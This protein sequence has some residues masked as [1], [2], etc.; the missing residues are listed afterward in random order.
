MVEEFFSNEPI[1]R[2]QTHLPLSKTTPK[3]LAYCRIT[4]GNENPRFLI[5]FSG[6]QSHVEYLKIMYFSITD[7][8]HHN[9]HHFS[10]NAPVF[11]GFQPNQTTLASHRKMSSH[12]STHL[13]SDPPISILL[14]I[15]SVITYNHNTFLGLN[16]NLILYPPPTKLIQSIYQSVIPS[17]YLMCIIFWRKNLPQQKDVKS[18]Q[19]GSTTIYPSTHRS[20]SSPERLRP[21]C[22]L[23]LPLSVP[24]RRHVSNPTWKRANRPTHQQVGWEPAWWNFDVGKNGDLKFSRWL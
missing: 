6:I 11:A 12:L 14:H 1:L 4:D 8:D 13:P 23:P 19:F 18:S 10:Q 16:W 22:L 20:P 9:E 3:Y 21:N 17:I 5:D 2:P 24:R 15:C 7:V